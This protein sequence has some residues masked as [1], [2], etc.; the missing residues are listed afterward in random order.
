MFADSTN[1]MPHAVRDASEQ[2]RVI[3]RR[4][5]KAITD[6]RFGLHITSSVRVGFLWRAEIRVG[7]YIGRRANDAWFH[8]LD[9]EKGFGDPSTGTASLIIGLPILSGGSHRWG[10]G[11]IRFP[12]FWEDGL[13]IAD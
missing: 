6:P 7:F 10:A 12:L 4:P 13:L 5:R 8:D 11:H 1:T 3:P 9:P 2:D